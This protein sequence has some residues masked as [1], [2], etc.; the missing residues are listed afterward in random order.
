MDE[1]DAVAG[2]NCHRVLV[3]PHCCP[4][5]VVSIHWTALK[6]VFGARRCLRSKTTPRSE[7]RKGIFC[8]GF[9]GLRGLGMARPGHGT[10]RLD[11]ACRRISGL[12][13][14]GPAKGGRERLQAF[15]FRLSLGRSRLPVPMGLTSIQ[16][17]ASV[18]SVAKFFLLRVLR[19]S[20]V[21]TLP[22]PHA[23]FG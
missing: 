3:Q 18:K 16:S 6:G 21:Q 8:R 15:P 9:R 13:L 20:V 22:R 5:S 23:D 7:E 17:V 14:N 4:R 1:T 10:G 2:P 19:V 12:P 11:P